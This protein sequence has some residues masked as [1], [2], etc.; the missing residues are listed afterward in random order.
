M[1]GSVVHVNRISARRFGSWRSGAAGVSRFVGRRAKPSKAD[2]IGTVADQAANPATQGGRVEVD[3][4]PDVQAR[5]LQ[6]R[7]HL[8]LMDRQKVIDGLELQHEL[9]F[10]NDVESV[11]AIEHDPLVDHRQRP[12]PRKAQ[13]CER[14]LVA[15]AFFIG[16]LQ[17][18]RTEVAVDLDARAEDPL[19][20]IPQSPALP[21]S[22]IHPRVYSR[23]STEVQSQS[24]KIAMTGN[25]RCDPVAGSN[26]H[27]VSHL[28]SLISPPPR[29]PVNLSLFLIL[30]PPNKRLV[31]TVP[32]ASLREA[33]RPAAHPQVV[34][35]DSESQRRVVVDPAG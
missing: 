23:L 3:E 7:Q 18:P 16:G 4:Q 12:L 5:Q 14:Q 13:A 33:R 2:M 15:Q 30:F 35:P 1:M 21:V 29:L 9:L 34:S 17:E 26:N 20:Q 11:T 10:D 24:R 19:R 31:L 25:R 32:R 8:R 28:S 6:V 22:L 27:L